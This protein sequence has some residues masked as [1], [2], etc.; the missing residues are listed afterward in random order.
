MIEIK[1]D[2]FKWVFYDSFR[3][4]PYI[5]NIYKTRF[6]SFRKNLVDRIVFSGSRVKRQRTVSSFS[7]KLEYDYAVIHSK[8]LSKIIF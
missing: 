6:G 8:H 3:E 5:D 7:R 4:F 2:N 1:V